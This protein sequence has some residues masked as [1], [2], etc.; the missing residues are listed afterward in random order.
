MKETAWVTVQVG[1]AA[2]WV[3]LLG[4]LLARLPFLTAYALS[5]VPLLLLL[6]GG[7]Y[8][9][10]VRDARRRRRLIEQEWR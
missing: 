8:Y 1:L 5:L 4:W 2:A 6:G 7:L 3:V 9:W 10:R